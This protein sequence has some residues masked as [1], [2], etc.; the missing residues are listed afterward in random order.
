MIFSTATMDFVIFPPRWLVAEHTFK[1]PYY[2]R[3]CMSEFMGNICG[4]YDAKGAGFGPGCSSLHSTMTPHGPDSDSYEKFVKSEQK[5][6][7]VGDGSLSFMFESGYL[8]K[9]TTFA[10]KEFLQVDQEYYKCW[11]NLANLRFEAEN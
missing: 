11:E 3:N 2:H 9:T 5:P 8:L 4:Q 6:Y 1:P 10:M 7:K